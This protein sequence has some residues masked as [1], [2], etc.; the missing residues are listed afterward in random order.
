M[1]VGRCGGGFLSCRAFDFRWGDAGPAIGH[2]RYQKV[3]WVNAIV[4]KQKLAV[5]P[6]Q[7]GQPA[8]KFASHQ[9][10]R[11]DAALIALAPSSRQTMAKAGRPDQVATRP[12]RLRYTFE[13]LRSDC[14]SY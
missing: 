12:R 10:C 3:R 14:R 6:L 13:F 8:A 11:R 2:T 7:R 9:V 1:Q 4:N 5:G